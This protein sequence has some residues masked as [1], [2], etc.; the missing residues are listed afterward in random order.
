MEIFLCSLTTTT[1][2]FRLHKTERWS[3]WKE[4]IWTL[5]NWEG[6]N[7]LHNRFCINT[8]YFGRRWMET[9]GATALFLFHPIVWLCFLIIIFLFFFFRIDKRHKKAAKLSWEC[10]Q[11]AKKR[12]R[13]RENLSIFRLMPL[14]DSYLLNLH[15]SSSLSS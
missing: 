13:E 9:F 14:R 3:E 8:H 7:R 11:V 12:G 5:N 15:R 4:M 10:M 1:N 2:F 6:Q